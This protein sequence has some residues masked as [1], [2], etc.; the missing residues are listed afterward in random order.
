MQNGLDLEAGKVIFVDSC[1]ISLALGVCDDWIMVEVL[2]GSNQC[3][4]IV[5]ASDA[6]SDGY[7]S[8]VPGRAFVSQW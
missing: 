8:F 1:G 2:S 3:G 7:S 6:D 5:L 4:R